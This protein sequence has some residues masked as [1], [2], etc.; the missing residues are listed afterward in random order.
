MS[1]FAVAISHLLGWLY[2]AAWS[3]SFY[4]QALL[5]YRRKS[6]SGLSLDFLVLNPLGFACYSTYNLVLLWSPVARHQYAQRHHGRSP[7]VRVNDVAFAVH[8]LVLSLITLGQAYV[9]KRDPGQR[10][11]PYTRLLVAGTLTGIFVATIVSATTAHFEWLDLLYLLS[12][13][14]LALSLL[15]LLPQAWLNYQRKSTIGWSI[16]NV[17]L[18]FSGGVLSLIQLVLDSWV[19][20]DWK[21]IT[22]N[23]GKLGLSFLAIGFD[24]LFLLQHYV[25]YKD[26]TL[27]LLDTVDPHR[28]AST[29]GDGEENERRPLLGAEVGGERAV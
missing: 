3:L 18:D 14:K 6:V 15:K 29:T 26:S 19:S 22:G 5:N 11:S 7:E 10:V 27:T 12:Y 1:Y 25:W 8:A 28:P 16:E 17:V 21:G 24:S 2:T 20:G 23:P 13:I 4:P 9:Y